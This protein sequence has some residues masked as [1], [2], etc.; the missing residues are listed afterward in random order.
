MTVA[1]ARVSIADTEHFPALGDP[2]ADHRTDGAFIPGASPPLVKTAIFLEAHRGKPYTTGSRL[3]FPA[4]DATARFL[5]TLSSS[6]RLRAARPRGGFTLRA[7]PSYAAP[8]VIKKKAGAHRDQL[9]HAGGLQAPRGRADLPA[10]QEAPRG[11]GRA[12]GTAAAKEIARRTPSTSIERSSC[13]RSTSDCASSPNG[14]TTCRSSTRP[15]SRA[16]I[17][18][19]SAPPLQSRTRMA[20]KRPNRIRRRRRE[21]RRRG[22]HLLE[23]AGGPFPCSAKPREKP[24]PARWHAGLRELTIA[25]IVYR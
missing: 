21:R 23:I 13:A 10:Q 24:S 1:E 14:S 5:R 19:S 15:R 3:R 8:V 11:G 4:R 16:A 9:H 6:S 12:G 2:G 22:R 25:K 17:A 7:G 18:S 20:T